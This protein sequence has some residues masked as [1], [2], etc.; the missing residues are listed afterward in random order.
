MLVITLSQ[1]IERL[2]GR[3]YLFLK[4]SVNCLFILLESIEYLSFCYL[5]VFIP[6]KLSDEV[7][8]FVLSRTA[9]SKEQLIKFLLNID[10]L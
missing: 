3:Q 9:S 10:E 7:F 8:Q 4:D 2:E 6:I 5:I 1:L